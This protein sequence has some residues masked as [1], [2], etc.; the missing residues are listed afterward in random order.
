MIENKVANLDTGF[1][2][3]RAASCRDDRFNQL[4]T[5]SAYAACEFE[6]ES[7]HPTKRALFVAAKHS[8]LRKLT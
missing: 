7:R 3:R 4:L 6:A 5:A 2:P 1:Y 8:A